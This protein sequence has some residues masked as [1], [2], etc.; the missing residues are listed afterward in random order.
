MS[1]SQGQVYSPVRQRG[2][3]AEVPD[4]PRAADAVDHEG[5]EVLR[6]SAAQVCQSGRGQGVV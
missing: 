2:P 3:L 1:Q 5:R 4:S 6:H